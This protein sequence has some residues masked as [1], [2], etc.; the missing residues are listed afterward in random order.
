MTK[1]E[2]GGGPTIFLYMATYSFG[3]T[4]PMVEARDARSSAPKPSAVET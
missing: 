4:N 3:A 2:W 1:N